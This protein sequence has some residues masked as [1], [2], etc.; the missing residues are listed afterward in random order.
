MT[1]VVTRACCSD[2]ACVSVCP[3]NC[4]HPTPDEP[5]YDSA[6]MLYIDPDTCID[7][8][9]CIDVCPVNAIVADIDLTDETVPYEQINAEF[10]SQE[11]RREAKA[12]RAPVKRV[13]AIDELRPL[14]VA[15]VGSGPAACY[16]AEE[17]LQRRDISVEVSMFERL[18]T[19][20]GLVRY[21][22]A[23][24]HQDTK[25]VTSLFQRT[26]ARRNVDMF[27]NVTVGKHITHDE[28]MEH[29]DAV[30]YA[31]GASEARRLGIP[32]EDLPGSHSATEFV[33]WYNGHPDFAGKVFDLS[34]ERAVVIGNGNVALDVARMLV[35]E[36]QDL[37]RTDMAVHAVDAL[38]AGQVKE[39][40]VLGRRGPAQAAFTTPELLALSQASSFDVH[41]D[42]SE[43][44]LDNYATALRANGDPMALAKLR[45]LR[46]LASAPRRSHRKRIVFRFLASPLE[47]V[48]DGRVAGLRIAENEL[49]IAPDGRSQSRPTGVVEYLECGLVVR[50][51]GYRGVSDGPMPIDPASGSIPNQGGRIISNSGGNLPGAY[52]AGWIKRGSTGV[53][54][55]N[56]KCAKGTVGAIIE[57]HRL[58]CLKA[59]IRDGNELR[60]LISERQPDYLDFSGAKAIDAYERSQGPQRGAPRIKLT[61]L[62]E[63]LRVAKG[64]GT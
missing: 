35:S 22:V 37:A 30:V 64:P 32:G 5:G 12:N 17:L 14:R 38:A 1:H 9:A 19:P 7:C 60:R 11:G 33:A 10:Y 27:L 43:S 39:V 41:V 61:D 28:L 44:E 29:H 45:I 34:S 4:I 49:I 31:V 46:T 3:V 15:I 62:S 59:P 8:G 51:I 40:V 47:I 54:G 53:I 20:W 2:A 56:K 26:A 6:E 23:P 42:L 13:D 52:V 18:P 48:G 16:T 50:S 25:A 58:G 36:P 63:M 21:G 24:D 57:D 55:T